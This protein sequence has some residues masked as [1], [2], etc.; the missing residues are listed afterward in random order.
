[1]FADS[2]GRVKQQG[3][4]E[5]PSTTIMSSKLQPYSAIIAFTVVIATPNKVPFQP[6]KQEQREKEKLQHKISAEILST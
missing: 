3:P 6:G 1:V 2:L 4:T 5:G